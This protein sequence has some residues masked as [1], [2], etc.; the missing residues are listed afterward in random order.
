MIFIKRYN[1]YDTSKLELLGRGTQG[2]VYKIDCKK[3]IKIFKSKSVC[4]GEAETLKMAQGNKHFAK[5]YDSGQY[6]IVREYI[7]G[8]EL[9]QYLKKNPLTIDISAKI[10]EVYEALGKVGYAR[11]DIAL[12][13]IFIT[14]EGE[15]K[16]ID[17]GRVMKKKSTYPKIML[18]GLKTLGCKE[19]FLIHVKI[20]KPQLYDKWKK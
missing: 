17:T 12:F 3:C 6:Y 8:V 14:P 19:E 16:I 9:N 5:L 2:K 1:G 13:H 7:D 15:F 4:K 11:Q 10:L 18:T 20:L